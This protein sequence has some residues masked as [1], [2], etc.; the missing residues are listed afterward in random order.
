MFDRLKELLADDGR[1]QLGSADLP[2]IIIGLGVAIVVGFVVISIA[3]E[4]VDVTALQS[5]DPLYNSS[6]SLTNA[7]NDL[8][9]LMSVVFLS[10]ILA[11]VVFYLRGV[12]GG[13]MR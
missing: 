12:R 6:E 13:G 2:T 5:G 9:G 11:V 3:S 4:T 1:G 10:I 8:F 7:T